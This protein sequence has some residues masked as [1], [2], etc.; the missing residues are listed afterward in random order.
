MSGST[1]DL[2]GWLGRG[3]DIFG[4]D[5]F[6]GATNVKPTRILTATPPAGVIERLRL[7][8]YGYDEIYADSLVDITRK[9]TIE[10]GLKGSYSD[11]SGSISSK[12]GLSTQRTE[13][14][15]FLK[16]IFNV[17]GHIYNITRDKEGLKLL[18]DEDFE[19]ALD[20][21]DVD[22]LFKAYG[23][24]LIKK[25]LVGGRAEYFCQSSDTTSIKEIEFRT[26]AKLKYK[27]VGGSLQ[28]TTDVGYVDNTKLKLVQG[29]ETIDTIGGTGKAAVEL[30]TGRWAEWAES[31]DA[32]P[33]FL[34]FDKLDGL[35]PIWELCGRKS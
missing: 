9:L 34:S 25:M 16:I 15:H 6:A 18:L 7:G 4:F 35:M 30:K 2:T 11:F 10:A 19:N 8:T 14:T 21:Y 24:H 32:N 23:T 1:E 13:K 12:F 3:I 20:K 5:P 33:A 22:E 17:G 29:R 26:A 28:G 27:N 31:C